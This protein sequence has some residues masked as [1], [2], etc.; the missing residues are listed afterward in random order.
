MPTVPLHVNPSPGWWDGKIGAH[1]V[2]GQPPKRETPA[3]W[4]HSESFLVLYRSFLLLVHYRKKKWKLTLQK[5]PI[6]I[7]ERPDFITLIEHCTQPWGVG[8]RAKSIKPEMMG[9]SLLWDFFNGVVIPKVVLISKQIVFNFTLELFEIWMW[10]VYFLSTST[11]FFSCFEW[12]FCFLPGLTS[13]SHTT[14]ESSSLV[15]F[16]LFSPAYNSQADRHSGAQHL[17]LSVFAC[18]LLCYCGVPHEKCH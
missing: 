2:A 4:V 1:Q 17:S 14:S 3:A 7:V 12:V 9:C 18:T 6:R 11:L 15:N 16:V 5:Y 10:W 8:K 13:S